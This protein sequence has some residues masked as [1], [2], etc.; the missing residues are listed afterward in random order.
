MSWGITVPVL[1]R[2]PAGPAVGGL[3]RSIAERLAGTASAPAQCGPGIGHRA[4]GCVYPQIAADKERAALDGADGGRDLRLLRGNTGRLVVQGPGR[5]AADNLGHQRRA[6]GV[7]GDPGPLLGI[8]YLRK[9]AQTLGEMPASL[10][11]EIHGDLAAL[12]RLPRPW[13]G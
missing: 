6:R 11:I 10:R 12:V 7:R 4:V 5:A 9:P 8:E 13:P 3:A 2:G 1:P